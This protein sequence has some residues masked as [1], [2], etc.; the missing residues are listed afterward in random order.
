MSSS[1][2]PAATKRTP[3]TSSAAS[4]S[5][6]NA[7]SRIEMGQK[8]H[9]VLSSKYAAES[10]M[11]PS[12]H[13]LQRDVPSPTRASSSNNR[14]SHILPSL[15]ERRVSPSPPAPVSFRGRGPAPR[16]RDASG[17]VGFQSDSSFF[18]KRI[19]PSFRELTLSTGHQLPTLCDDEPPL[20]VPRRSAYSTYVPNDSANLSD[21]A[22]TSRS[23]S[24]SSDSD[25]SSGSFSSSSSD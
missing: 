25:G 12:F 8:M 14:V 13:M 4:N 7:G 11:L 17:S 10:E 1:I 22:S 16:L 3:V 5:R 24:D 23:G 19:I 9:P 20:P 21:D 18:A 2:T 6:R 15:E